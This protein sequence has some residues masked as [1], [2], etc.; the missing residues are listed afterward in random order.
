MGEKKGQRSKEERFHY[1][2]KQEVLIEDF[3]TEGHVLDIGGGGEGSFISW[4]VLLQ[5]LHPSSR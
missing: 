3:A 2:E 4:M 1:F 5:L